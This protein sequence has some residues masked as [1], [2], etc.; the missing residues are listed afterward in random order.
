MSLLRGGCR[1]LG[2]AR[3]PSMTLGHYLLVVGARRGGGAES[4][5]QRQIKAEMDEGAAEA[6]PHQ[7]AGKLNEPRPESMSRPHALCRYKLLVHV[8]QAVATDT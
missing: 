8:L 4:P 6:E 2:A 1:P 5:G 3:P 7:P